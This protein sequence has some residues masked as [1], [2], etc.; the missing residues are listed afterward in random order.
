MSMAVIS[1]IILNKLNIPAIIGYILT[2]VL[3]TYFFGL[4]LEDNERLNEL[5]ELGI[6][7]LM[8]MIGLEFSFKTMSNIKKEVLLFGG[9]QVFLSMLA[10]FGICFFVMGFNFD[11]SIIVA[12]AVSLSSTAIVLKHLND[13]NQTQTPYGKNCVG[14]L[15]FQDIAVIPILLMI[16]LLSNKEA[17]I[18]T[19]LL[20]TSVSAVIVLLL[21]LLPG[22][23]VAKAILRSSAKMKTDEVFL[24]VVLLIILGAAYISN[25]FGFS[26]SL[27]AF[28]AG[29]IISNTPYKYQVGAVLVY[30]RDLLLGIFF[31]TIGMQIDVVFLLKYFIIIIF[32]VAGLIIAKTAIMY[33]FLVFFSGVKTGMKTA[34]SLSQIGEFSFAIFL[35]A[36]QNQILNLHLEGGIL[37]YINSNF[38][39]NIT[40]DEIYQFLTLMVIFSMIATPF[41]LNKI[42]Q[43]S[44]SILKFLHLSK[45]NEV[46]T[47]KVHTAV[48]DELLNKHVIVC[49]YGILGQGLLSYFAGTELKAVAIDFNYERVEKGYR[50]N[51]N[52]IYGDITNKTIFREMQVEK[53]TAVIICVESISVAERAIYHIL[54]ISKF[55]K[56]IVYTKNN[57][58]EAKYKDMGLYSVIN[59]KREIAT[60]IANMVTEASKEENDS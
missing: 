13:V 38:L 25:Y 59:G 27:G 30:F 33:I 37:K 49:G 12:S 1:G 51:H 36:S 6:I 5:A 32:L 47:E 58:S 57:E 20:T 4:K 34:L 9:L 48:P 40:P 41:I 44:D 55:C 11:T 17:E 22:R 8:F 52:V 31:I 14:I 50:N 24:G 2:G 16:K 42:D 26:M 60:M 7:F 19:L 46:N 10:F 45:T 28:L 21:L 29:M 43:Y 53:S 56:I 54:S 15:I 23:F 39:D 3:T 35:L 18:S